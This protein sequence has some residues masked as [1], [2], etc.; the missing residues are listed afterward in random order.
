[1]RNIEMH[2]SLG[3]IQ[4]S[5]GQS[6]V[7][8]AAYRA[9]EKLTNELTGDE[10]DYTRK[11]GV[12]HTEIFTP[13]NAPDWASDREQLWNAVEQKEKRDNAHLAYEFDIGLPAEFSQ[14]QRIELGQKIG[15]ELA[16]RYNTAVDIAW[17]EPDKEGDERNFH[18]HVMF[19]TRGFDESRDDGWSKA[20]FRDLSK[21]T[22]DKDGNQYLD[23]NGEKTSIG[24]L[25]TTNLRATF[26]GYMN[27][28]AERDNHAVHVEHESFAKRGIELEPQQ[29]V[30]V[31]A[32]GIHRKGEVSERFQENEEIKERNR[33]AVIAEKA[34]DVVVSGFNKAV[35]W[36]R[37]EYSQLSN[38]QREELQA[39]LQPQYQPQIY[40]EPDR[41]QER[42]R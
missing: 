40:N 10:Y 39:S 42:E 37:N 41:D 17:H 33:L 13:D 5:K 29:H 6:S 26:A 38:F 28:I 16:E 4:R 25:E 32:M 3:S 14:E 2:M 21:D 9:G 19:P 31:H 15:Q 7:A 11:S 30:G 23:E 12:E 35:D 1:M 27:D 18:A 34:R 20:K 24:S 22:K 36:V 8:A